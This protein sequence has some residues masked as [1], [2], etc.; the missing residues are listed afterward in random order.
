MGA[1]SEMD[2]TL[3]FSVTA[4]PVRATWMKWLSSQALTK[5]FFVILRNGGRQSWCQTVLTAC[6]GDITVR[7]NLP[8]ASSQ[9]F[10]IPIVLLHWHALGLRR[11]GQ[12]SPQRMMGMTRVKMCTP[13]SM[14]SR[15]VIRNWKWRMT[16]TV[17]MPYTYIMHEALGYPAAACHHRCC[18]CLLLPQ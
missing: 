10:L 12:K 5:W 8:L 6:H 16:S 3:S 4:Q 11:M 14:L 18:C 7:V 1:Q 15:H 13:K 9:Q 2:V 17:Y